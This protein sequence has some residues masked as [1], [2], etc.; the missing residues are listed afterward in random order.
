[1]SSITVSIRLFGIFKDYFSDDCSD[2]SLVKL[3]LVNDPS[4]KN[5]RILMHKRI[6]EKNPDFIKSDLMSSSVFADENAILPENYII[7]HNSTLS[8][9]PPVSGG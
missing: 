8:I 4:I 1:M 2:G 6:L 7:K 5:L 9:L 3:T